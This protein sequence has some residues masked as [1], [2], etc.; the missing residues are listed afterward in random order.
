VLLT[1]LSDHLLAYVSRI[2]SENASYL[3]QFTS[4]T[5]NYPWRS[6][7][8]VMEKKEMKFSTGHGSYSRE[9]CHDFRNAFIKKQNKQTLL[10]LKSQKLTR[11]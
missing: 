5:L 8:P 1:Y 10:S 11:H 2:T 6:L 9:Y 4:A 3:A 7:K